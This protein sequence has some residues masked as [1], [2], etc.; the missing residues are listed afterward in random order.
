MDPE[1]L[2]VSSDACEENGHAHSA[3]LMRDI[4]DGK[5]AAYLVIEKFSEYNDE[6]YFL[7]DGPPSRLFLDRK[8]ALEEAEIQNAQ[9]FRVVNPFQYGYGMSEISD[10][11]L[12]EL[13]S[14][15]QEIL[16]R[17]FR[18]PTEDRMW[19]HAPVFPE[20]TSDAE[21]MAISKLFKLKF[22]E[23]IRTSISV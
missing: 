14:K 6:I 12:E 18:M 11:S 16:G 20:D 7:S 3:K 21:M 9:R 10:C 23:V 5:A 8:H 17:E 19:D 2:Q 15:I 22:F 4:S 1:S 13:T